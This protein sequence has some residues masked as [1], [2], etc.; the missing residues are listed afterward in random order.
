LL[1]RQ[2]FGLGR[3]K[4]ELGRQKFELGRQKF[5]LG[6]HCPSSNL[7]QKLKDLGLNGSW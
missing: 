5:A 7:R 6:L 2:K 1:G 3:L 4:F